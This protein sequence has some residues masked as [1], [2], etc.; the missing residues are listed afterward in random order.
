MKEARFVYVTCCENG[1]FG[2]RYL[3]SKALRPSL[4]ITISQKVACRN[5]VS[6]YVDV[7][8]PCRELDLP[9]RVLEDYGIRPI[10]LAGYPQDLVVVNGWN[11]LIRAEVLALFS[12]G[13]VALHAGHPPIGLG[14]APLPWNIIKSMRDIEVYAFAMTA[15]ADDGDILARS[16]IEITPFDDVQMLYE[17]VMFWGARLLERAI[18]DTIEGTRHAVPQDRSAAVYYPK[19]SPE[20]GLICFSDSAESIYDFVRAQTRPYPGA[21]TFLNSRR[22]TIWR[23][24]PFDRFSFRDEPRMPGRILAAL[25]SGLVVQ[26]GS[27]PLWIL[28]AECEGQQVI[29]CPLEHAQ[30]FVGKTFL[31]AIGPE[32]R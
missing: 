23:A 24:V 28:E 30:Q 10:D 21:F 19:R 16:T 20:D 2:L 29:P 17:K 3:A 7:T 22:W 27:G 6:G 25:P 13:G 14:R 4:V 15:R 1:L 8:G 9:V 12:N 18:R 31:S 11:R 26:T 32:R 5:R